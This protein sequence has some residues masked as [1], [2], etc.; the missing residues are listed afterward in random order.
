MATTTLLYARVSDP[1]VQDAEDKVSIN[2]QLANMQDLCERNNWQVLEKFVDNESYR[3]TQTPTKGKIVNPSGERADRPRFLA[4]LERIKTG[5][6]DIV[7]CW[8]DDRL[9]RHPRVAVAL[10][11]ALDIGDTKRNGQPKIEIKDATGATIDRFTLSIKASIWRE[12]NKRR[13]ERSKMGKI[14]TLE[15]GRWPGSYRRWGYDS[16]KESGKRGRKI[17]EDPETAPIVR[18]IFEMYDAG[19]GVADISR[20]L[21]ANEVPQ[22]YPSMCKHEWSKPLIGRIL[23]SEEYLG[24][25][26]WEF[27]GGPEIEVDIPQLVDRDLF[28]RVQRRIDRNTILSTRNAKGVYLLQGLCRCGECGNGISVTRSR[29]FTGGY[30]YHCHTASQHSD[31]PHP[32]PY[33]FHGP[34]LDW[35]VW[36]Q[37]VDNGIKRPELIKQHVRERQAQLRAQ[38]RGVDSEIGHARTRL[39]DIQQQRAFY[40]R[41]AARSRITESEFDDRMD[42]TKAEQKHWEEELE[43]L[44]EL[45]DD[46]AQVEAGLD[47][48]TNLMTQIQNR[49]EGIDVTPDEL[50]TLSEDSRQKILKTRQDIVRA[51][52]EGV[53]V[54]ASGRVVI[55]GLLDGSELAQFDLRGS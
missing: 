20:Y 45:R 19:I 14:A 31:E 23:R 43:R 15:Q 35:A 30:R 9:V 39:K 25:T 40:Q 41:Q 26:T 1:A 7:L 5:K 37:V 47:Y 48:A 27:T 42:E 33:S 8:R 24:K 3:A 18:K 11:D 52:C 21:V 2:Q 51:L 28:E 16:V 49:L 6:P 34:K 36:R 29:K 32:Q 44:K 10:E 46:A 12:E 53:T 22:I 17:I 4:M 54:H 13:A 50:G 38:G 55:E